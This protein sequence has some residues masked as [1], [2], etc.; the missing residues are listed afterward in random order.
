MFLID[1]NVII[2]SYLFQY[3][4]LRELFIQESTFVSEISRVEVLG[5]HKLIEKE[6]LYFK[7][8]FY[9]IPRIH[10]SLQIFDAAIELR[11]KYKLK[12]GD[13]IIAATAIVHG[14][15]LYTRNLKDFEKIPGLTCSNPVK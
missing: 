3:E 13:S 1:S 11:K 10:P 4:Y 7:E 5:Y 2:D 9:I 12:L 14:L 6:N 8:V 15:S